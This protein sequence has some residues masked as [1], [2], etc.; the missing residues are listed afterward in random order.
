MFGESQLKQEVLEQDCR[1][2]CSNQ[3]SWNS[4]SFSLSSWWKITGF[5]S[6]YMI[7]EGKGVFQ[8]PR[9]EESFIQ[10]GQSW[11][12]VE[13]L[14]SSGFLCVWPA[15]GNF[16]STTSPCVKARFSLPYLFKST[17][18]SGGRNIWCPHPIMYNSNLNAST[19]YPLGANGKF[20][21]LVR[22]RSL[23]S[24]SSWFP[25][26]MHHSVVVETL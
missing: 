8:V 6:V 26:L 13:F 9:R 17:L 19:F 23:M 24:V 2:N 18:P 5:Q 3:N 21:G 1:G 25:S 22:M 10:R 4:D 20:L 11:L 14:C 16:F 15:Q 7:C 12:T